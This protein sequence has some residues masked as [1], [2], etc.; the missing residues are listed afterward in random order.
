MRMS[1]QYWLLPACLLF[2][3][4]CSSDPQGPVSATF[5]DEGTYGVNAGEIVRVV[6]PT[7]AVTVSVPLGVGTEPLLEFGRVKGI[8]FR[9]ILLRFDFTPAGETGK[10]VSSA[11]L[12]LPVQIA[13]PE[14]LTM[15][16]TI[17][18]LLSSFTDSDSISAI[19][20]FDSRPIADSLGRTVDTLDIT[21]VNDFSLDT[22]IVNG[23][24]S[25]RRPQ[26]GIC[27]LWV[28]PP[29]SNSYFEINAHERGTDPPAVIVTFTDGT[30]LTLGSVDDY[31]VA[32]FAQR[33][34]NCVG[35]IARRIRFGFDT[36]AIP[37]R[38]MINAA[39]LVLR[40]QEDLGFGATLGEQ[41]VF[42]YSPL[43]VYYLYAPDSA[44]TLSAGFR[45]GT[46]VD[47]GT[48][49]PVSAGTVRLRL[50]GYVR[51]ILRAKRANTGLVLQS[52]QEAIRIQ[53][54]S[55][56]ASGANAPYV[57]VF[58]TL[59]ADFGGSR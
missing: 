46:G 36:S 20:P 58:Y 32:Y 42:G 16:V 57:E 29:D 50:R 23:W 54:A 44:D 33:G 48:F 3:L 43:F 18:E 55:F 9:S 31:S 11:V 17:H 47:T 28:T 22:T 35:G 14:N 27:L 59:P 21:G 5:I 24:I 13:T 7:T 56:V 37:A 1:L 26:N 39:F 45:K 15:P 41:L 51:D 8:E 19:P 53:R 40:V 12:H 30:A 49:D 10:R 25:G 38:A 4:S 6:L 52:D 34:L 2:V